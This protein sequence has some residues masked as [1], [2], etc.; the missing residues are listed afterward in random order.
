MR[1]FMTFSRLICVTWFLLAAGSLH[2]EII[3]VPSNC[4]FAY[5]SLLELNQEYDIEVS[6]I[7]CSAV[8]VDRYSDAWGTWQQPSYPTYSHSPALLIDGVAPFDTYHPDHV[9][10]MQVVGNSQP[11]TFQIDPS[12]YSM[13]WDSSGSLCVSIT[14]HEVPEP[15][16]FILSSMGLLGLVTYAAKRRKLA[17]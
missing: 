17:K 2:A 1:G 4:D 8:R 11:L 3:S 12:N 9:Y 7:I 5:S 6:G 16:A 13:S 15:S 14:L 10:K